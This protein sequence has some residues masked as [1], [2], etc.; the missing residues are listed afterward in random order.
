MCF[1]FRSK[2]V[3]RKLAAE[4]TSRMRRVQYAHALAM[5]FLRCL[6]FQFILGPESF[7]FYKHFPNFF[8]LVVGSLLFLEFK[9]PLSFICF[10][11]KIC[12]GENCVRQ[13]H[14][15]AQT[16]EFQTKENI[17]RDCYRT[18]SAQKRTKEEEREKKMVNIASRSQAKRR[19]PTTKKGSTESSREWIESDKTMVENDNNCLTR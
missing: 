14:P 12:F 6:L 13:R 3:F 10:R 9:M 5:S 15:D 17:L 8:C 1:F 7:I 4:Y 2:S 19:Q 16:V 11:K 18:H